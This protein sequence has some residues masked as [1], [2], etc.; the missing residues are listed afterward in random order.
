[1]GLWEHEFAHCAVPFSASYAVAAEYHYKS[2]WEVVVRRVQSF[3]ETLDILK[4]K[5][6]NPFS[7][8]SSAVSVTTK[9]QKFEYGVG[10]LSAPVTTTAST[11]VTR[12]WELFD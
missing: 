12:D 9:W 4:S 11:K 5:N 6:S 1:M 7:N 2:E 10:S 8:G 3:V